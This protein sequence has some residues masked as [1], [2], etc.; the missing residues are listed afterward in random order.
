MSA[1]RAR[2][3]FHV[4]TARVRAVFWLL[5]LAATSA[6]AFAEHLSVPDPKDLS[7]GIR[8][9]VDL[10]AKSRKDRAVAAVDPGAKRAIYALVSVQQQPSPLKLVRKVDGRALAEKL[11]QLLDAQ[12][13]RRAQPGQTPEIVITM[14][15]GRSYL[16]PNPYTNS[17]EGGLTLDG[18]T[19]GGKLVERPPFF[20]PMTG[21][22]ERIQRADMEKLIIQVIAWQYPPPASQ[23]EEPR[24]LWRTTMNTDDPDHRD[25]NEIGGKMLELA[26]PFFDREL[27]EP[28]VVIT[29]PL[30]EGHVKLGDAK[31]IEEPKPAKK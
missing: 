16:W 2:A 5:G 18:L 15:F 19:D 9:G 8:S 31:V 21:L 20:E 30:P 29:Q 12:G 22:E 14:R 3:F 17:G 11:V 7:I 4:P 6:A 13:F 10:K 23:K 24:M 1:P 28:E 26:A 27:T 25:L